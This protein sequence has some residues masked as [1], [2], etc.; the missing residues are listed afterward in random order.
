[1]KEFFAFLAVISFMAGAFFWTV[2]KGAIQEI[3]AVTTLLIGAV[4][5]A[6][7]GIIGAI[8]NARDKKEQPKE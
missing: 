5:L 7:F 4:F 1:M 8:E 2:A 6:A 3:T